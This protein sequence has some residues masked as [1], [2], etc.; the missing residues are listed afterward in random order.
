M[1][2]PRCRATSVALATSSVGLVWRAERDWFGVRT[3]IGRTAFQEGAR[4]EKLTDLADV[5]IEMW[6]PASDLEGCRV[7]A[8]EFPQI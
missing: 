3:P 6:R 4:A 7:G 1:R 2:I 8:Q 5:T